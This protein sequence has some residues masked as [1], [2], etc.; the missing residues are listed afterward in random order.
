MDEIIRKAQEE[1]MTKLAQDNELDLKELDSV[2]QP[3][4]DSC[5]KDSISVIF[6]NISYFFVFVT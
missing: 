3:I 4:I 1:K 2:L 6:V 5:T